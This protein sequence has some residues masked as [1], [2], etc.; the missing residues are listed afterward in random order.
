M[1][2]TSRRFHGNGVVDSAMPPIIPDKAVADRDV[3]HR[4]IGRLTN[5]DY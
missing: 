1:R 3:R 2:V 5:R 4:H